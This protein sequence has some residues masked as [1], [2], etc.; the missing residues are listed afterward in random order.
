MEIDAKA[1]K[2]EPKWSIIA[3]LMLIQKSILPERNNHQ[4]R[5][6]TQAYFK[7]EY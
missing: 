5:C 6:L 2:V 1:K 3:G 7:G 4:W